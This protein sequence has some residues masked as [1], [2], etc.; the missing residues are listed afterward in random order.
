MSGS[1]E[2]ITQQITA[3]EQQIDALGETFFDTYRSFLIQLGQTARRQIILSCYHVCTE[4]YP[5]R[6]L[7]LSLHERQQLQDKIRELA[8]QTETELIELLRPIAETT[9]EPEPIEVPDEL[10]ALLDDSEPEFETTLEPP[11]TPLEALTI[12]QDRL[13]RSI[14]K[15]LK[16]TSSA[17][18]VLLQEVEILPKRIPQPV[19]D[20]ATPEG[21]APGP[22]LLNVLVDAS[23]RSSNADK[24]PALNA[25]M[26]IVAVNLRLAE[27]EFNDPALMT[28][29]NK[30]RELK[31]QFQT[32]ARDYQKKRREYVIAEAQL[33]W[34]STWSNR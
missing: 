5:K 32:Q 7:A 30:L 10:E 12:W 16:S 28:W 25:L 22:N 15:A 1:I 31:K 19:L 6:F 33:V 24:P 11:L 21:T 17:A 34:K 4:G 3:L 20:A 18:N 8:E 23:E 9:I 27:L 29:R 2:Q 13:E 26:H 14:L